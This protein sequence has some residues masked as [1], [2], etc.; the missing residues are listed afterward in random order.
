VRIHR[1]EVV[2][3]RLPFREPYVT[4]RG[5]LEARDLV[6]LRLH[7]GELAGVGEAAPLSLRGGPDVAEIVRDL[8]ERCRPL[9]E[10]S[11]VAPTEWS[12][13]AETCEQARVG[14]QALAAV[15]IA[16]LDLAGKIAS[17]PAWKL[18]GAV[19]ARPVPCNATLVA[20]PSEAVAANAVEHAERGF[21]T[22][23]LKVGLDGDVDQVRIVRAALGP[24]AAIRLDANGV[25]TTERAISTLRELE[26]VGIELAEQP[27]AAV[28]DLAMVR[29][30]TRVPVFADESV[31][32][33]A[34]AAAVR[35]ADACDGATVKVAKVGGLRAA[36]A[37][38]GQLPVYLSSAL[39]GPPGIAAAA[40]LAQVL[41]RGG[42]AEGLAHGLA[43]A[44]LFL[45]TIASAACEVE[46]A[47]LLP[48]HEPGLGVEID[49]AALERARF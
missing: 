30:Q 23:K 2:P 38:A 43:T 29:R 22:F 40:H 8:D 15:E 35:G 31:A 9:L 27:V 3:Y 12:A 39:D 36:L 10:S 48:S 37:I 21:G 47:Q 32:S 14:P 42:A 26:P 24:E 17:A 7:A 4:A 5:R 13:L 46:K 41:P 49:A 1:I 28:A 20:G 25:W 11:E 33:P 6:L 19:E 44:E 16:L 18:L 34:E 45:G